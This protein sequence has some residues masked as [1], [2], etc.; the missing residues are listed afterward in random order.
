MFL[1][2]FVILF[3]TSSSSN[4]I[5]IVVF[6]RLVGNPICAGGTESYCL[7][8]RKANSSYS[9]P[10]N[11]L[12]PKCRPDQISSPTCHCAFPYTGTLYFRAPS[13]S[14]LGNSTIYLSLHD[15]L[16]FSFQSNQL[17]VDS[18][19]LSNPMKNLDSYLLLN[20]QAF[21]SGQD[22]FSRTGISGIAFVLSNQT[23]KPPDSFG[24]FFFIGDSY[25][26]FTGNLLLQVPIS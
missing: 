7:I 22:Y 23:F 10:M 9:T 21:P 8:P 26:Y 1:D 18:V 11:C 15:K 12:A 16:M 13:F 2:I 14:D 17:P 24:P 20:L 5:S 4:L 3:F 6:F 25:E 19:S